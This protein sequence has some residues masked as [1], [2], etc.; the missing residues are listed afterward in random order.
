[1][2]WAILCNGVMLMSK[3]RYIVRTYSG[4]EEKIKKNIEKRIKSA[5]LESRISRV[6]L[7]TREECNT[8]GL[9][10]RGYRGYGTKWT[11][12]HLLI[13]MEMDQETRQFILQ[14]IGV[15]EFVKPRQELQ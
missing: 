10:R 2:L 8:Y 14:T 6:W 12:E 15:V 5:G 11:P 1:M 7:P 3:Q 4:C 9:L 13:E